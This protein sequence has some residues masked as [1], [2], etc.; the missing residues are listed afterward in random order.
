M[1]GQSRW[2]SSPKWKAET[3]TLACYVDGCETTTTGGGTGG[4]GTGALSGVA[5]AGAVLAATA[6]LLAF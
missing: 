2:N 4:G 1:L 5:Y 3:I 6:S